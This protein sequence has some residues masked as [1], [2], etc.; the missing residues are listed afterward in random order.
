MGHDTRAALAA[1]LPWAHRY[2]ARLGASQDEAADLVQEVLLIALD[3]L[4]T[5]DPGRGSLRAWVAAIMRHRW[6]EHR[7]RRRTRNEVPLFAIDLLQPSHEVAVEARSTLE[8]LAREVP[9]DL[10]RPVVQQASGET[11]HEVAAHEGTCRATSYDRARRGRLEAAAAMAR[12]NDR[13]M[14]RRPRSKP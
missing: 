4:D 9:P 7:R 6:A 10:W 12:E 14:H 3:N 5:F 11:G 8:F 2:V 13:P 1:L